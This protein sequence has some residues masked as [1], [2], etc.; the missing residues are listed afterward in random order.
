LRYQGPLLR[1]AKLV[2]RWR[3]GKIARAG[4]PDRVV[5]PLDA[6][7]RD[8]V[9]SDVAEQAARIERIRDEMMSSGDEVVAPTAGEGETR[10]MVVQPLADLAGLVS[11][12]GFWGTLLH[13]LA[14]EARAETILELGSC[15]GL[16]GCYLSSAPSCRRFITV[17]DAPELAR[18]ASSNLK[19]VSRTAEVRNASF[20][21]VIATLPLA[22]P[23]D[24]VFID[25]SKWLAENLRWAG[26]VLPHLADGGLLVVDDI[27]FSSEMETVWER[28]RGAP[29]IGWTLDTGRLGICV[30]ARG[31]R[32]SVSHDLFRIA[33]VDLPRVARVCGEVVER[34]RRR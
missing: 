23:L 16:S 31:A 12:P 26:G 11:L 30:R 15:V 32:T 10:T 9:P 19:R 18:I 7:L 25:G 13:L 5:A 2:G 3:L 29:D 6:V 14:A 8:D 21:D 4:F 20:D 17:E 22:E 34:L 28:L 27:H 24:F 33:G 1:G